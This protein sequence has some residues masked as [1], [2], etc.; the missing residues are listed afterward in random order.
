MFFQTVC[1]LGAIPI[2]TRRNKRF[3]EEIIHCIHVFNKS[4]FKKR[5]P[6][7]N[8]DL[9]DNNNTIEYFDQF[10]NLKWMNT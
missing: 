2:S 6:T 9:I 10:D 5:H 3:E 4:F 7:T 1:E 8:D